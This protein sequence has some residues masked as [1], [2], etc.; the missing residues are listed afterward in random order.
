MAN[1]GLDEDKQVELVGRLT[2]RRAVGDAKKAIDREAEAAAHRAVDDVKRALGERGPV[3]RDDGTAD[4]AHG[5][6]HAL[7]PLVCKP[8]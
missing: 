7:C 6:E 2:A 1:P 4:P 3:L 5:E 8:C